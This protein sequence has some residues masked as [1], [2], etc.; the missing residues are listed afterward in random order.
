MHNKSL[1]KVKG[2][3]GLGVAVGYPIGEWESNSLSLFIMYFPGFVCLLDGTSSPII[4]H[5]RSIT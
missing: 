4:S 1:K 2:S 3:V 5:L